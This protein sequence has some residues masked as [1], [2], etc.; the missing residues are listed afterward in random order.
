MAQRHRIAE[1]SLCGHLVHAVPGFLEQPLGQQDPLP[2]QPAQRRGAGLLDEPPG[3]RPRRHVRQRRQFGHGDLL[4]KVPF[5]PAGHLGQ[6]VRRADR[7][8]PV[9]ELRLAAVAA[10]RDHHPAGDLVGHLHA[11]FLAD[12]VEAGGAVARAVRRAPCRRRA[13]PPVT[14]TRR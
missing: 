3:E 6:G 11:L 10:R 4:V 13:A 9:H 2:G 8:R 1:P 14:R 5:Q 12:E 7:Q